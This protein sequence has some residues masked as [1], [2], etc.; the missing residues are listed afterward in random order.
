MMFQEFVGL[1]PLCYYK[2]GP[3]LGI[4]GHG[5]EVGH[6]APV[7]PFLLSKVVYFL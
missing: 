2:Q 6:T 1:G 3:H 7:P 5:Q 4:C